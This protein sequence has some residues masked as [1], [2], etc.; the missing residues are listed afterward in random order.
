MKIGDEYVLRIY[1]N[2]PFDKEVVRWKVFNISKGWVSVKCG[3]FT[4]DLPIDMFEKDHI[5]VS[6]ME[7]E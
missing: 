7:V 5:H 3:G 1:E 2:C 4:K 6:S